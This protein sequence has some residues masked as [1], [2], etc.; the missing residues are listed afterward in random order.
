MAD[1]YE[2]AKAL[3][4][5]NKGILAADESEGTIKRRFQDSWHVGTIPSRCEAQ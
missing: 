2:T 5:G 3:V 1:L 4:T